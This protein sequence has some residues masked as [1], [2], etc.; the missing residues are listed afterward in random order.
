MR[1]PIVLSIV[2][3][4]LVALAAVA[5][6]ALQPAAPAPL[7]PRISGPQ[8]VGAVGTPVVVT[9]DTGDVV[10]GNVIVGAA[11]KQDV[12]PAL[13][14]IPIPPV[15]QVPDSQVREMGEPGETGEKEGVGP[16]IERAQ[17]QDSVVQT[18]VGNAPQALTAGV[19]FDGVTNL[20]GVYPPD[21]NGDVG[22]NHYVQMVNLHMQIFNKSGTSLLGPIPANQIWSGFG[23]SCQTR[24]DGDPVVLYDPIADRWILSQFTAANPYG[25][26]VA[27]STTSDP[28]GSY[29]RYF[30]Q[31]STTIF[32][33]YPK[34]G[35]WPDGYYLSANRFSGN[36]FSGGSAI[37]LERDKMLLG[38]T[39][40]FVQFNTS[41]SYGTL[42]PSDLN[43]SNVPTGEPNFFAEI[44][45][46]ALHLWKFHIDWTTTSN[47]T[48]TG[49]TS[50][51]VATYNVLCSTTRNCVPQPSTSVKLDGLGDRLMH[52]LAYRKFSDHES[53]V[54]SHN[55]N[56]AS[57]GTQAG[58]RWYEIRD[59][60]G[61]ATLYQ[62]GTYAP[63]T[64]NRWLGSLAMD[65][66]GNIGLGYSAS[67]TSVYPG[68]RYTGRLATDTLGQMTQG[69]TTMIAGSGSQTGTGYRWGDYAMMAVDPSD[70]CTFWFTT[71][72]IPST[73]T[74]PWK[75][76]IGSFK[77]PSCGASGG[78]ATFTPTPTNTSTPT[79]T[80][81][82]TKTS[83]STNTPTVTPTPTG[84][85]T[86]T[87]TPTASNTPTAT[88]TPTPSSTPTNT[89]TPTYT[90]TPFGS[91]LQN[92]VA[93]TGLAGSL[94][95]Q[96]NFTMN[97]PAGATNLVFAMSG[98]TGDADLYVRFGAQ[99][100]TSTYDCR[101]Y[102]SGNNETCSFA[103]PQVGTYYVMLVGYSAYSGV[104]LVGSY[105]VSGPTNTPTPTPTPSNT[106]TPTN[107]PLPGNCPNASGGYCRSNTDTRAWIAGTTN[108]SI[109]SDDATKS[110]TL[111]FNFTFAG[112]AYLS[113]N[114]SSNGNAHF[115]TASNAYSNVAIP[116]TANPNALLAIFWDDLAPNLGGAIYTG[117]S[118]TSP[119]RTFV[120]EWRNVDHYGVSGTN[121]A[122][123]EIQLD[124][125]TNHVWF[126]YQDT[127]FGSAS[128]NTGLSATSGV[129]NAA[130]SA[131]NQYSYNSAALINGLVLHFWPQ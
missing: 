98:G 96:T 112:T 103:A 78:T 121:G 56:A 124:E 16:E 95:S 108:Q 129:E 48:F 18:A 84:S 38:Q 68:I 32:Y 51:T 23:G 119:N 8:P 102:V 131:G 128:Y 1:K 42:L 99:P 120:I 116:S 24:N 15:V 41:S 117:V 109:T 27:V 46:T 14:D 39:A 126:L 71:E 35:V 104:S 49:P 6:V 115:G 110:V 43:G 61:T 3:V 60:N 40:R 36:T 28:T 118:G 91:E 55:V 97:V 93:V 130:G 81:T 2:V 63:D 127:D 89:P 106:P 122:T 79:S 85:N 29:Y 37:A 54:V 72:Y 86:P 77:F 21:T 30:F 4:S 26:C 82:P 64:T 10:D 47:S 101:P 50:L 53:L 94:N 80:S 11:V 123:F 105:Q 74:A 125:G 62:Q 100:T 44:G 58:V 31:F 25:E 69:E 17:T 107:T 92:G 87:V 90:S 83:T 65:K 13:R 75:T 19:N 70:D 33:D 20:D 34:L 52:S 9:A 113:V 88:N 73:G 76:R 114:V 66:D 7:T 111:P 45:S 57:S 12:S 59:P 22:P 5:I 67:S